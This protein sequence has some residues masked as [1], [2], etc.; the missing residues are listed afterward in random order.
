MPMFSL[1]RGRGGSSD[2]LGSDGGGSSNTS[3]QSSASS[4]FMNFKRLPEPTDPEYVTLKASIDALAESLDAGLAAA[5][6]VDGAWTK[7]SA[8]QAGFAEAVHHADRHAS[9]RAAKDGLDAARALGRAA[10]ALNSS[11]GVGPASNGG[12]TRIPAHVV[13]LEQVKRYLAHLVAIQGRYRD[14]WKAKAEYTSQASKA[15]QLRQR[16]N[17]GNAAATAKLSGATEKRDQAGKLYNAMLTRLIERMQA[18][19]ERKDEAI[20]LLNNA[21]WLQQARIQTQMGQAQ[22]PAYD[23]ARATEPLLV[24][25]NIMLGLHNPASMFTA[26]DLRSRSNSPARVSSRSHS[27]DDSSRDNKGSGGGGGGTAI[28]VP[29]ESRPVPKTRSAAAR[30][31][32]APLPAMF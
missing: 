19:L 18:V 15:Q 31:P 23:A 12:K 10:G 3:A 7:L 9:G 21:F 5:K 25:S 8:E 2:T 14:V 1:I 11:Q 26:L 17:A 27:H 32:A 16:S 28:G 20:S 30:P 13:A 6:A 22:Q 4:A 29:A 24:S